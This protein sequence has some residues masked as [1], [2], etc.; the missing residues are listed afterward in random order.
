[1]KKIQLAL[2]VGL[3]N[4]GDTNLLQAAKQLMSSFKD[5]AGSFMRLHKIEESNLGRKM[6][7]KRYALE[8]ERYTLDLDLVAGPAQ[9]KTSLH[10][11]RLR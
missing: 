7:L 8:F 11:F 5:E 10:G 2:T 3:M 6:R 9:G 1:M 4:Q